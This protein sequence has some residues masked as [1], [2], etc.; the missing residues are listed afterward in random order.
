MSETDLKERLEQEL[1]RLRERQELVTYRD[2]AVRLDMAGPHK[3]HRLTELLE[4]TMREDHAA[5]RP[6]RAAS[7]VSRTS[8]NLPQRGFFQLLRE[9]GHYNGSDAGADAQAV[10]RNELERLW[11]AGS[12]G[13]QGTRG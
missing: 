12:S 10:H 13:Q 4:E 2:L 7:V 3:I 5:G 8:G 1:D 11:A 9:L 6:L